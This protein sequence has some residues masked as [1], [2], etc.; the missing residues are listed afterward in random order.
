L[1]LAETLLATA[2][3]LGDVKVWSISGSDPLSSFRAVRPPTSIAF[4][5]AADELL[6]G[7]NDGSVQ[8]V[9]GTT[10]QVKQ[11]IETVGSGGCI[12]FG[13]VI[14]EYSPKPGFNASVG[15]EATCLNDSFKLVPEAT[16][17]IAL[18]PAQ[19]K[20]LQMPATEA[21]ELPTESKEPVAGTATAAPQ[22]AKAQENSGGVSPAATVA[23]RTVRTPA[24]DEHW[25]L[26]FRITD[27][28]GNVY[29]EAESNVDAHESSSSKSRQIVQNGLSEGQLRSVA[30]EIDN[31]MRQLP[32]KLPDFRTVKPPDLLA[33]PVF[34][35][36]AQTADAI[37][38]ALGLPKRPQS[39]P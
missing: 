20:A 4:S 21:K 22:S 37:L 34:K 6:L 2:S 32:E 15:L 29:L 18:T 31:L 10:G 14:L 38:K 5:P 25:T 7:Y 13:A 1:N 12:P 19:A 16:A 26:R 33:S 35:A 28:K 23:T 17:A 27:P 11:T 30:T 39:K 9:N 24:S 8:K 36:T 3:S